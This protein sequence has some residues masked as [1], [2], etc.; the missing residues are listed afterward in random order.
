MRGDSVACH[1]TAVTAAVVGMPRLE[2]IDQNTT[3]A[4]NF[5]PMP[6]KEMDELRKRLDPSRLPLEKKLVRH[7][8]GPTRR[9]ELFWV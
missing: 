4:R 5:A 3:I 7:L 8:D 1:S 2:F 9:P 6:Q